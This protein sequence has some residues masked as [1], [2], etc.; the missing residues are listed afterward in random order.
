MLGFLAMGGF[1]VWLLK[2]AQRQTPQ[3]GLA[4]AITQAMARL[5][6]QWQRSPLNLLSHSFGPGTDCTLQASAL[7]TPLGALHTDFRIQG[8]WTNRRAALDG[9]FQ[10][11]AVSMDLAGY[12]DREKL[13]ISLPAGNYSLSYQDASQVLA[14]AAPILPDTSRKLSQAVQQL[15]SAFQ[16]A[17]TIPPLP[18]LSRKQLKLALL[19]LPAMEGVQQEVTIQDAGESLACTVITYRLEGPGAASL[20]APTLGDDGRLVISFTLW[21][22]TLLCAEAAGFSGAQQVHYSLRFGR[23][24]GT[25]A[26]AAVQKQD[27][28]QQQ[29]AISLQQ[30]TTPQGQ[31]ETLCFQDW[32]VTYLWEEETGLLTLLPSQL[33]CQLT[34][35]PDGLQIQVVSPGTLAQWSEDSAC[36][37]TVTPGRAVAPPAQCQ[38]L[39]QASPGDWLALLQ[40]LAPMAA[41]LQ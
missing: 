20:L 41:W 38:D 28:V 17:D 12:L 7:P 40:A 19:A 37:L 16:T 31:M 8:D 22:G 33:R 6:Q 1:G 10:L 24:D 23:E 36:C 34:A 2:G 21:Q 27:G 35:I 18:S 15:Q 25:I 5:E 9:R 14:Q 11:G 26:F 3:D 4:P 30:R 39:G 32:A 13:A 29:A